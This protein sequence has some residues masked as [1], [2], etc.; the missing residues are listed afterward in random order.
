VNQLLDRQQGDKRRSGDGSREEGV[1]HPG[2]DNAHQRDKV[3]ESRFGGPE[4][5]GM[6]W[7]AFGGKTIGE[8]TGWTVARSG[9]N[10]EESIQRERQQGPTGSEP[11][12]GEQQ[13]EG[14]RAGNA[15]DA[16]GWGSCPKKSGRTMPA[17][18]EEIE[19]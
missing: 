3:G 18:F 2:A 7:P 14:N 11:E 10:A 16:H 1:Q 12:I 8:P 9:E 13:N 4:P 17:A 6:A 15:I 19:G 5:G